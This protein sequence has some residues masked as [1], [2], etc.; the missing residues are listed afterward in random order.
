MSGLLKYDPNL[1]IDAIRERFPT[2]DN[3]QVSTLADK[4]VESIIENINSGR[5]LAFIDI[6]EEGNICITSIEI[7]HLDQIKSLIE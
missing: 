5:Q 3:V 6:D 7:D 1:I 4:Y 2:L